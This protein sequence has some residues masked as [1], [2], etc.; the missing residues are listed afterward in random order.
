VTWF[1]TLI[2]K[3]VFGCETFTIRFVTAVSDVY[4]TNGATLSM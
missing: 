2:Y 1:Q 4:S 3:F